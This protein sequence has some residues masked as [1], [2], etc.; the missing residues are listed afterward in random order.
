M[1][2]EANRPLLN[3]FLA[4]APWLEAIPIKHGTVSFPRLLRGS[5]DDLETLLRDKY[6]TS[7]VPG[8][9]FGTPEHFR[10]GITSPTP[11][12]EEGL[13]RLGA[14]LAEVAGA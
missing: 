3:A 14:A 9:F 8:R 6:A 5:V 7:V 4:H 1:P 13:G 12:L 11:V 10:I 2:I